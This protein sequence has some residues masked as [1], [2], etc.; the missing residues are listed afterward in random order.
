[1]GRNPPTPPPP[2]RYQNRAGLIAKRGVRARRTNL[3][4]WGG[5]EK[6]GPDCNQVRVNNIIYVDCTFSAV[7]HTSSYREASVSWF[8]GGRSSFPTAR[9]RTFSRRINIPGCNRAS[10]DIKNRSAQ[11]DDGGKAVL[12]ERGEAPASDGARFNDI[13][14]RGISQSL[15]G[16]CH[17]QDLF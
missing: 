13:E 4:A 7:P 10:V 8:I 12:L 6:G 11:K 17:R 15:N 1:L 5:N 14:A 9:P 16:T 3:S 2:G